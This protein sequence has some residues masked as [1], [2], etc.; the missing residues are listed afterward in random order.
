MA[1]EHLPLCCGADV[2][3]ADWAF[4][5]ANCQSLCLVMK[6]DH[7]ED[8]DHGRQDHRYVLVAVLSKSELVRVQTLE[9]NVDHLNQVA[10]KIVAVPV[11][12]VPQ[13]LKYVL[14]MLY[15]LAQRYRMLLDKLQ[16]HISKAYS[17]LKQSLCSRE[18]QIQLRVCRPNQMEVLRRNSRDE[19]LSAQR[20]LVEVE[21]EEE[22]G[23]DVLYD[24]A[25]FEVLRCCLQI[26]L[27]QVQQSCQ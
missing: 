1:F 22:K 23:D 16:E 26:A 2:V 10:L 24:C 8:L 9:Q 7:R 20:W 12:E 15:T 11:N 4:V 27:Q 19:L 6:G 21:D 17:D 5:C 14:L 18:L 13:S 25:V 3:D